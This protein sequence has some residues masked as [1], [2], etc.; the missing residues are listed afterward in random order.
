[1]RT[2]LLSMIAA[3]ALVLFLFDVAGLLSMSLLGLLGLGA[4]VAVPLG[5][6]TADA[7]RQETTTNHPLPL[8]RA[9]GFGGAVF[10]GLAAL[11][12]GAAYALHLHQVWLVIIG[13][14]LLVTSIAVFSWLG[15]TKTNRHK[16]WTHQAYPQ[17][18]SNRFEEEPETAARFGIY[19][20][21]IWLIT[22]TLILV[23]GFTV[24]WWWALLAVVGGLVATMLVLARMMF[25]QRKA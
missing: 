23:L 7:L 2:I 13:A 17:A 25:G 14:L 15:A 20:V 11:A 16:A 12:L 6:V 21:V 24:G 1:V 3:A 8:G 4:A 19:S 5:I 18:P 9:I 22:L 10:A